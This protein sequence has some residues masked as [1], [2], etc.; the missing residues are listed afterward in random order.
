M[1]EMINY[2]L[3]DLNPPNVPKARPI[4]DFWGILAQKV[5]EGGWEAKNKEQLKDRISRV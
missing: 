2:V 5:Y 4:E 1:N 3:V